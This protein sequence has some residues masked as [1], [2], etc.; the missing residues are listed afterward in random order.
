MCS[1]FPDSTGCATSAGT[2]QQVLFGLVG[3]VV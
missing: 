3:G 1:E 2:A